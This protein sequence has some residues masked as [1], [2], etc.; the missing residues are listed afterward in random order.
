MSNR[1]AVAC[2][3]SQRWLRVVVVALLVP[4]CGGGGGSPSGPS[5]PVAP[6]APTQDLTL[7]SISPASGATLTAR[8]CP[9]GATTA[10][11][12]QQLLLGFTARFDRAVSDA[13]VFVEL[14]TAAGLRCAVAITQP[15]GTIAAGASTTM[16]ASITLLS[17]P[18]DF[19]QFCTLPFTTTR[20]VAYLLEGASTRILTRE[21]PGT[22]TFVGATAGTPG[23]GGT[24]VPGPG[25][26]PA[27]TPAP[28]PRPT[29]TPAP[30]QS[31]VCAKYPRGGNAYNCGDFPNHDEAQRYHDQCDPTDRNQLDSDKDGK[32]CE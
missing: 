29:P 9:S 10:V 24:P 16:T 25:P 12:T 23:P 19:P 13:A 3:V 30:P 20:I 8:D 28:T 5:A 22:Y 11:C 21:F 18:P 6:P 4:S 15:R 32:V 2:L 7:T 31:D 17:I 27:P 26:T 14:Y 1:A